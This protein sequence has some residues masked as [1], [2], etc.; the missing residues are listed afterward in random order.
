M[1]ILY[2][3]IHGVWGFNMGFGVLFLVFLSFILIFCL[4]MVPVWSCDSIALMLSCYWFLC[5]MCLVSLWLVLVMWPVLFAINSPL[6]PIVCCRVLNCVTFVGVFVVL[7]M[8][9]Q[10]CLYHVKCVQVQSSLSLYL[11][12]LKKKKIPICT[13]CAHERTCMH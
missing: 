4:V 1:Y 11:D 3:Y 6:V 12:Y 13:A 5:S 10:V 9:S 7:F 8:P 2:I